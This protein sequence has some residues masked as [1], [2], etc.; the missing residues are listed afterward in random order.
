MKSRENREKEQEF[1]YDAFISYRHLEPD[2]FVTKKLHKLL[3][4]F[5]VPKKLR[6]EKSIP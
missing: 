5:R 4:S 6:N 3:E 2:L 1:R